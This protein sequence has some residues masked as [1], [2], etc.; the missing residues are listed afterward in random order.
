MAAGQARCDAWPLH[1]FPAPNSEHSP[2]CVD[3]E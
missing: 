2:S 1:T 3:P